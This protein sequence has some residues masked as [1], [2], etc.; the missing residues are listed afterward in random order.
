MGLE[1]IVTIKKLYLYA[2][3]FLLLS[4]Y[5]PEIKAQQT[6][7]TVP[8]TSVLKKGS[9]YFRSSN[10]FRPFSPE[11]YVRSSLNTTYGTG[12]NAE[13]FLGISPLD[14]NDKDAPADNTVNVRLEF[15]AKKVFDITK[16]TKFAVVSRLNPSLMN[17]KTPSNINYLYFSQQIPKTGSRITSG[18]YIAND[19]DFIPDKPGVV[20]GFEQNIIPN[21]LLLA[22][23][24]TS[25]NESFGILA[26]GIKYRPVPS[27]SI[28]S[29]VLIPNGDKAHF[30]FIFS[31]GKFVN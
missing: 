19:K 29:G 31:I 24:W 9:F 3:I 16:T 18:M 30:G 1:F 5:C 17:T 11:G 7:I 8:S 4:I 2:G 10:R 26:P 23:D 6:I 22:I 15:A 25:R 27:V 12:K 20:L 21:K 13:V 14:I 28:T